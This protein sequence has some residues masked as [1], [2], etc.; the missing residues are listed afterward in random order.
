MRLIYILL[1][2]FLLSSN[3]IAQPDIKVTGKITQIIPSPKQN[4]TSNAVLQKKP[5]QAVTLL[6]VQLSD[7]A[8]DALTQRTEKAMQQQPS[9][10]TAS[11]TKT[12]VQLGMG[13]VPVMNQG[14]HGTC[15]T[16]AVTAAI[17]AAL[18]A[19]D[20]ISQ[21]CVLQLGQHLERFGYNPSGWDGSLNPL[22]LDQIRA[23]GFV[24]KT[25]EHDIGCG[26]LTAYPAAGQKPEQDISLADHY[27]ISEPLSE[28]EVSWTPLLDFYQVFRD[29]VDSQK[30]LNSVKQALR[31][32]DRMTFGVLI[33]GL[34]KGAAG[35][36]GKYKQNN[37]TWLLSASIIDDIKQQKNYGGHAMI[38]TGFNDQATAIDKDGHLHK[39]LL[40]LRNSWGPNAG[41]QGNFYMSYDYFQVLAIEIQRIRSL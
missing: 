33:F 16:F 35:A 36:S 11:T 18:D 22:V 10:L 7:H 25:T 41:D 28:R 2:A 38:I 37:D 23:F 17:D 39:G 34:N 30:T 14:Q 13:N 21:L 6:N 31:D 26:G 32:H 29:K 20:Y 8:W 1:S 4:V 15:A 19:G 3:A 40:T 9:L 24:N 5:P 27:E 12:N